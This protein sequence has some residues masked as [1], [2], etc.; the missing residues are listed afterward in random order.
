[1]THRG[2]IL[3]TAVYR[4]FMNRETE[5]RGVDDDN[6]GFLYSGF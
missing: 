4:G 5:N 1:M 6:R 3:E 2:V